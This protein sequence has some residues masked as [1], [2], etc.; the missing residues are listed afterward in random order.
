MNMNHFEY[1]VNQRTV[2]YSPAYEAN[3]VITLK[4]II[5]CSCNNPIADTFVNYI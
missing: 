3:F 1:H 2:V 5:C 4:K